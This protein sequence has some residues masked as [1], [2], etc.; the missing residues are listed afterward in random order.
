ML[1]TL[2]HLRIRYPRWI[3]AWG[4]YFTDAI[5]SLFAFLSIFVPILQDRTQLS[6]LDLFFIFAVLQVVYGI[7]FLPLN[8]YKSEPTASRFYEIQQIFRTT[9]FMALLVVFIDALN[10]GT[11]LI[12]AQEI[13]RYWLALAIGLSISRWSFRS[14]Q[15]YL[16]TKGYG[17]RR[18]II[19]G[20]NERGFQV[21][22]DIRVN[23]HQGFELLGFVHS[24]DDPELNGKEEINV[25][26]H[27]NELKNIILE[28]QVSEVI[29]API[30]LD[31]DH[32]TRIITRANG[33]PVSIKIVPDLHEVIS[34]LARTEQ[35]YGLPL[36]KVNPNLDT[37]YNTIFKR[38][39][40]ICLALPLLILSIPLW[41]VI[42]ICI[43]LDSRGPVLYNQERIGKNHDT[44]FISKFRTMVENAEQ[45]TGPVWA[46]E[47]DPRITRIGRILRRFRL[48][49]LPQL[50]MVLKGDMSMIGPRPERPFFVDKLVQE[51]PFYYRRH[52]IRPGI[53]GWA[54][55]KHPYDQDIEDVRQKLKF[56]F[57]YIENLSFSLDLKIMVNT[58]W[59]M[60]SGEGR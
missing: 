52:K 15:K 5:F 3:V 16:L 22:N 53:T 29:V 23:E 8:L 14:I 35:I 7:I 18:T 36:I 48:D 20:I 9:F 57:Y 41:L 39:M 42:A 54:Q 49:E 46:Q 31:H 60:L 4:I 32:V 24:D 21:A 27:E 10:P 17:L 55:I 26:G 59:V 12:N 56:D 44:F 13:L 51:Y 50:L 58:I 11:L 34:G 6:S 37:V 47:E 38:I 33:S 43:K 30:Q 19:V 40:D 1:E 28:N 2:Q 25:V 45:L